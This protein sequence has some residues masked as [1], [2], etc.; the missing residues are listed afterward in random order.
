MVDLPFEFQFN[1]QWYSEVVQ[2]P[3]GWEAPD[4]TVVDIFRDRTDVPPF[5]P[6][7]DANLCNGLTGSGTACQLS[8][9][10]GR[11][12]P[13]TVN[14]GRCRYHKD[15]F[16]AT[17][18]VLSPYGGTAPAIPAEVDA[19]HFDDGGA[20][21]AYHVVDDRNNDSAGFRTEDAAAGIESPEN[22]GTGDGNI[23]FVRPDE[24]WKYTVEAKAGTYSLSIFVASGAGGTL[25]VSVD[26]TDVGSVTQNT[27]GWYNW[28]E[29]AVGEVVIDTDGEHVVEVTCTDGAINFDRLAFTQSTVADGGYGVAGY[30]DSGYGG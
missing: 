30:G 12:D 9:N 19:T 5:P 8:Y 27:G 16:A 20:D 10:W 18:V 29:V 23:G 14:P 15:Q 25:S 6:D 7:K 13:V 26:G 24:W 21:V 3:D 2:Q 22:G 11:S 4:G 1:G 28:T 17:P